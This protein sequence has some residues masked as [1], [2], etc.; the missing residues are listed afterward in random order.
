V[1]GSLALLEVRLRDDEGARQLHLEFQ[2]RAREVAGGLRLLRGGE[3]LPDVFGESPALLRARSE[4]RAHLGRE[5]EP[6]D[7]ERHVLG[8]QVYRSPRGRRRR[9]DAL[10]RRTRRLRS[11][12]P[13][14]RVG[15]E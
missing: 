2:L 9:G 8:R 5:A 15:R 13:G 7:D 3:H 1:A 4:P 11:R 10:R 6:L 12:G 14:L